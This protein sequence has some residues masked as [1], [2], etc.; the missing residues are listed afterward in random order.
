MI[1][2]ETEIKSFIKADNS[3]PH[4]CLGM[5]GCKDAKG[6]A[7]VVRAF[8][9]DAKSCEVVDLEDQSK[10][11][12]LK[13]LA[14]EGFFEGLISG[15]GD[16]PFRY[17]LRTVGY[18][19]EV[20]QF[21]DPYSFLPT[22]GEQDLYLFNEGTE[23][24]M[25]E[26]LG[27]HV[28]VIDGVPGV[29]FAVWAPSAKR[30]SVVGDFNGWDGRY[31]PMRPLGASGVW[32]IFIPGIG[33]GQ[34]YKYEIKTQ[35]GYLLM[36]T[37]PYGT[38]FEAPPNNAS[39]VCNVRKFQ[40]SD[41]V[42]IAAREKDDWQRRPMNVYEV[43]AG[44]WKRIAEDGN[45]PLS[46]REMA[47]VLVEYVKKMGFTHIEFMPLAEH[48]FSGS[49][50]YQVTGFFAPTHRF[51]TPDDFQHLVNE[52]HRHGIG[53]IMDWVPGH[54]PMDSFALAQFDGSHLYEHA[55]PRQG[56]HQ[57]WGTYI[58]N[59]GRHEVRCFLLANALAWIDRYHIDGLRVDAVASMLYLDYSRKAGEWIPN[60][61][62]GNENLEAIDFLRKTNELVHTL[63]PGVVTI[64]EESTS[65]GGVTKPASENGLGFDYKWN[66]GW[67][68]DTLQ[69]FQKDPIH[70]K[71]H[72]N[73]LTFGMIYQYSE[74]FMQVFSHDEVVHG[75]GSMMMKMSAPDMSGKAGTL[76]ALYTLMW[77]W[78]GKNTLFMGCEFGQSNEWKY[79]SQLDWWLLQYQD[80]NGVQ[81]IVRD[82][83]ELVNSDP[84][85]HRMDCDSAGF[86]WVSIDDAEGSVFAFIRKGEDPR[87]CYLVV[88]HY[89]PV[90]RT[91]YRVGVPFGGFWKEVLNSNA[92]VY[93]GSGAGNMGGMYSDPVAANGRRHSLCVTL[94]GNSTVVF[95]YQPER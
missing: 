18:N 78:P 12:E 93:G 38:A 69:Y 53:V 24:R 47:N 3:S 27:A 56:M 13:L 87:E 31:Y 33:E 9:R 49:W 52:C 75:K 66:M 73:S 30:V 55:D 21:Y 67:M 61:Y 50:G 72:Q 80:H 41:E 82:L 34:K 26:K 54:F 6:P 5:H 11:Y 62:G 58:F 10:R 74:N 71:W 23:Y 68:H 36:K 17:R 16:K 46:Y 77:M 28:R 88:G 83:N 22:L 64:A 35:D 63:Y 51:G 19:E 81:A 57:D 76:R 4:D 42:W 91:G 43:H 60:I 1:I 86:E 45:R 59:Y 15:R 20:R 85:L 84:V 8:L 92:D 65:F 94:P 32:E 90:M 70:R 7:L 95:K 29:S 37:D 48:P 44:S 40:W 14:K 89:T 39:I 2:S 79:D 25:Y